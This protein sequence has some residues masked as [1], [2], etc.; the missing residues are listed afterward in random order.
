MLSHNVVPIPRGRFMTGRISQSISLTPELTCVIQ[1]QVA[2][3]IYQTTSE[4]IRDALRLLQ[5]RT[6]PSTGPTYSGQ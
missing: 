3:S 5:E 6:S 1:A 2:S 4:V